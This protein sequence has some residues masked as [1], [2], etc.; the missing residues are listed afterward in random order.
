MIPVELGAETGET[1][2]DNALVQSIMNPTKATLKKGDKVRVLTL[3]GKRRFMEIESID[4]DGILAKQW[5]KKVEN[6]PFDQI[7][8]IEKESGKG[9][10]SWSQ[11]PVLEENMPGDNSLDC[12]E[13]E[14]EM[15]RANVLR[16][17][18]NTEFLNLQFELADS[19]L[20][21]RWHDLPKQHLESVEIARNAAT[22]RTIKLLNLNLKNNCSE[23]A[24]KDGKIS[25]REAS[26]KIANLTQ[27]RESGK[28]EEYTYHTEIRKVLDASI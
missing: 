6:V 27:S 11:F 26:E 7:L 1:S 8:F 19:L 2:E 23:P 14:T 28:M 10:Q 22:A 21:F 5:F 4:Q 18:I 15:I 25:F 12:K 13:I 17:A 20:S 16:R 9:R 3:D 24:G